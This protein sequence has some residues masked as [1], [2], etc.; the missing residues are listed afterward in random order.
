M[1]D[2]IEKAKDVAGDVVDKAKD[3][4]KSDPAKKVLEKVEEQAAKGGTLGAV[5]DKA[6]DAIDSRPGNEG[7][8]RPRGPASTVGPRADL[9]RI[10]GDQSVAPR[11]LTAVEGA[12][13]GRQ[14]SLAGPSVGLTSM[15][16]VP[17]MASRWLTLTVEP[18]ID[19]ISTRWRPTG[20]G[21]SADLVLKTPCCGRVRSSRGCTTSTS[22]LARSSHVN[23][24]MR[25]A[26]VEVLEP[27]D[28]L[29]D[30]D[31]LGLLAL[32]HRPASARQRGRRVASEPT[33]SDAA[34]TRRRTP[35]H[36]ACPCPS[37]RVSG[38]SGPW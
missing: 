13:P 18:S 31:E 20:L 29:G 14:R 12:S 11:R 37:A 9:I 34:D 15:I 10:V 33:R 27:L 4:A 32:P 30:E 22:R 38:V 6:D 19:R 3:L 17:S 36:L 23:S 24:Q 26:D 28:E 5:A 7:L 21:R 2:F 25:L 1:S 35:R 16:G 8:I